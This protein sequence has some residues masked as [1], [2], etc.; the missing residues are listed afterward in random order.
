MEDLKI[1]EKGHW[2]YYA[3]LGGIVLLAGAIALGLIGLMNGTFFSSF[4]LLII[5]GGVLLGKGIREA[6]KPL[7]RVR[8]GKIEFWFERQ[9]VVVPASKIA[10]ATWGNGMLYLEIPG[11]S[12]QAPITVISVRQEKLQEL[13]AHFS[14]LGIQQQKTT[15]EGGVVPLP[16][17]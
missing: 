10:A 5:L 1:Y 9:R 11:L 16:H 4:W 3:I 8:E 2:G 15:L 17:Q 7:I 14:Q 13:Q 6:G 12:T